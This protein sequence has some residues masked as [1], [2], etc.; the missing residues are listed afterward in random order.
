MLPIDGVVVCI[1]LLTQRE[2]EVWW[3][4]GALI[5]LGVVLYVVNRRISGEPDDVDAD[6]IG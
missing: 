6:L 4:A 5:V 3:R 2:A 1:G